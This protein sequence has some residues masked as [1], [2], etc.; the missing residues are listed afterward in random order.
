MA[1]TLTRSARISRWMKS[2][3]GQQLTHTT[4]ALIVFGVAA[5]QSYWHTL[6]VVA[7]AGEGAHGVGHVMALA[8]DGMMIV[9]S[10]YITHSGT[11]MGKAI[12]AAAF[13]IGM[14]MTVGMNYLAADPN[15]LSR[16][17]AVIPAVAL[18]GTA[19]MLHWGGK[20]PAKK[21]AAARTRSTGTTTK[22]TKL[23]AV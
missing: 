12:S 9:A 7:R 16:L 1:T 4:P 18:I 21:P 13:V 19:A 10:R 6:E 2:A 8:V 11:R 20:K 5:Y 14:A 22:A 3:K 23:H 17:I 15:P